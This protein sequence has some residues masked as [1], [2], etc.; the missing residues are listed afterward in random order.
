M[1]SDQDGTNDQA[2]IVIRELKI[3]Q[4]QWSINVRVLRNTIDSF[5]NGEG[6]KQK[7]ILIDEEGTLI[8]AILC[9]KLIEKFSDL[10]IKG[11]TY[12]ITNGEVKPSNL[13]Y[14]TIN[15]EKE[16]TLTTKT[17]IR[18][19]KKFVSLEKL[20]PKFLSFKDASGFDDGIIPF[21]VV[22]FVTTV[23]P[24]FS[25]P[26]SK[27]RE[28]VIMNKEFDQILVTLWGDL[29]EIEGSSLENL[30]DAKP[31]VALL[32]VIGRRYLGE[33]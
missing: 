24:I 25:N 28:I 18:E 32:S 20:K 1:S 17:I 9:N 31:V 6:N 14:P 12:T 2:N 26:N 15:P 13:K 27:R 19:T 5:K 33:F 4:K 10:L 21:D 29:A 3:Y 16:L 8:Q 7:L 23:K 30:K 22:G 11:E